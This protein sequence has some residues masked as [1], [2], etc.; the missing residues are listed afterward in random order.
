MKRTLTIGIVAWLAGG[1][2]VAAAQ[3]ADASKVALSA[4]MTVAVVDAGKLK[5]DLTRLAWSPDGASFYLQTAERDTRGG[6]GVR[7]YVLEGTAQQPKGVNEEPAWAAA[8]WTRKSSQSAPGLASLRITI[9]QQQRLVSGTAAPK[10]GDLAKGGLGPTGGA[11][12]GMG[13]TSVGDA[14]SAA[15]GA[16]NVSVITLKLKGEVVGEFINAPALPG[17]TFGWGPAGSGLIV[18]AAADGRLMIMDD[19]GRK[20][21]IQGPKA[22]SF[23]GWSEDGTRIFF[24]ERTGRKKFAAQSITVTV[25]RT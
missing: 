15:F 21:E 6:V 4:P 17:T 3:T 23:P 5:G 10:G 9:D 12:G 8:Y 11:S 25:P 13:G 1:L 18:F 24:L 14:T 22:A 19:Q 7:H 2:G 16:Q 20:Q